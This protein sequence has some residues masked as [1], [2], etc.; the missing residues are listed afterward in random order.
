MSE[1][2]EDNTSIYKNNSAFAY[3]V[4]A[5]EEIVESPITTDWGGLVIETNGLF[6]HCQNSS[7]SYALTTINSGKHVLGSL[8]YFVTKKTNTKFI[9]IAI[10]QKNGTTFNEENR[11]YLEVLNLETQFSGT[12]AKL[13]DF[14]CA[15]EN[16]QNQFDYIQFGP[17]MARLLGQTTTFTKTCDAI[18]DYY[19]G[20]FA[21]GT[22]SVELTADSAVITPA[23]AEAITATSYT[24]TAVTDGTNIIHTITIV[25]SDAEGTEHTL[26]YEIKNNATATQNG[27]LDGT[28]IVLNKA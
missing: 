2:N 14:V 5:L 18:S 22:L 16:K 28:E 21:N 1:M 24:V 3:F 26:T 11:P 4:F 9:K 8:N 23:G 20:T 17:N 7:S 15:Y 27:L 10:G 19:T 13:V 12:T 25:Y 6:T